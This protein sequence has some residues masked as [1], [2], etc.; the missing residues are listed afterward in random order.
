ME[1]EKKDMGPFWNLILKV[2][3]FFP[4]QIYECCSLNP[5]ENDMGFRHLTVT[6]KLENLWGYPVLSYLN[7]S[8]ICSHND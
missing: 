7:I 1:S 2:G 4:S 3:F 8:S 5:Q 6:T